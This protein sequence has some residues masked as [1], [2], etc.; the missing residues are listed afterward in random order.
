VVSESKLVPALYPEAPELQIMPNVFATG[1]LV[2]LL[3][4]TCI[5]AINPHIDWPSQQ[6]VGT[7][8]DIKHLAA[9]PAGF[10]I[11]SSIELR[12]VDGRRL[13]FSVEAHDGVDLI[14]QGTHERFIIDRE[15][16]DARLKAKQSDRPVT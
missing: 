12:E 10:E 7:S 15:K 14:C 16:F 3:E 5:K 13:V 1:F 11:T 6:S 8:I 9:T 2:G 4:W